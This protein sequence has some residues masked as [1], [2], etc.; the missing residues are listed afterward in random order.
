M[1]DANLV[2]VLQAQLAA[3]AGR[4]VGLIDHRCVAQGAAAIGAAHRR[5]ARRGRDAGRRR[6]GRTTTTCAHWP[7]RCAGCRWSWPARAW[8]SACRRSIGLAP[9]ARRPPQLPPARRRAGRRV[10][11]LFG[12]DQR[13]GGRLHRGRRRGL[14]GRPAAT[15]RG[16][17]PGRRGAGL[18]AAAAGR[19]PGAGLRHGRSPTRCARYSSSSAPSTP[20]HWWSRRCRAS[21][22]PGRSRRAASSSS[23][24]A[25]PRAPA[26]RRWASAQLRIGPQIDP[27]V[28]WCHA[29][30]PVRA[31]G[32]HLALKSGNFGG[33]RFL[34][35]GLR[36]AVSEENQAREEICRVGH[37]L[38]ERGYVHATAGN[39]SVR[40]DDGFLIT[41]TDACLGTLDP[42]R[43]AQVD[44]AGEQIARRPR[45]QDAGAAPAHLR[46]PRP[47]RAASSTRTARTWWR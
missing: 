41:P 42:A 18:G 25:R 12:R 4:R 11:Q 30:T 29:A 23:P 7:R 31:A 2:R 21:P 1:T 44:A 9:D 20:A 5:A 26:C 8:R 28:P 45:Q 3:H 40:L 38:F 46:Q 35:P 32:L 47:R 13:A 34:Q 37:S 24:A 19:R 33:T 36:A 10:G 22:R 39:I 6:R 14:R 15:G 17:R 27:G 43:L 16:A